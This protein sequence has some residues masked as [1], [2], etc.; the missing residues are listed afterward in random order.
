MK[1]QEDITTKEADRD[2][3]GA[4]VGACKFSGPTVGEKESLEGSKE[5]TQAACG[6]SEQHG[7]RQWHGGVEEKGC[8]L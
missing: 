1:S 6:Q 4:F 8:T 2:A 5:A 7:Y 3:A